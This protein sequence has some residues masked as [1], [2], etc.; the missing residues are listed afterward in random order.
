LASGQ[1]ELLYLLLAMDKLDKRGSSL[2]GKQLS[3]FIEEPSAHL[4][5]AEQKKAVEFIVKIFREI[6]DTNENPIRF[7]ITTH[8]PFVLEVI[9]NILGKGKLKEML[10]NSNDESLKKEY[11]NL[12]FYHL[13]SGEVGAFSMEDG[14]VIPIIE[15]SGDTPYMLSEQIQKITAAIDED[16]N[17]ISN[18]FDQLSIKK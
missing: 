18:I 4:F 7:F 8:S 1:Q 12:G 6:H 15:N 14:N 10:E 11:E 3:I 9:N 5:P 16:A 17:T 13:A 2:S